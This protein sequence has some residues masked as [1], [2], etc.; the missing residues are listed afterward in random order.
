MAQPTVQLQLPDG[1]RCTVGPDAIV[2][3]STVAQVRIDDPRLSTVHAEISWR[4]EGFVLIARGGRITVDR[5]G[6]R[7]VHLTPGLRLALAPGVELVVLAVDEGLAPVVPRTAGRD[8]LRF[9]IGEDVVT[10]FAGSGS[11]PVA[12][13]VGLAS[14]VA[15]ALLRERAGLAW[16]R[17]AEEVWP[18]DGEIR[19]GRRGWTDVD[20]RRFRNRWDQQLGCLRR[21]LAPIRDGELLIVHHGLVELRLGPDDHV[22][23]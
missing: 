6:V 14:R 22:E 10:I 15:A 8:R 13:L 4:A 9:T 12:Q 3:R 20:E 1:R 11:E 2:G 23:G 7:E 17:V 5:R 21:V 16:D 18:E 19:R